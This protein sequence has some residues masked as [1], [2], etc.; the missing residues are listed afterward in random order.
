VSAFANGSGGILFL[1]GEQEKKGGRWTWPGVALAE[2][3]VAWIDQ[4]IRSGVDPVPLFVPHV[5]GHGTRGPVIAIAIDPVPEPPC[6]TANGEVFERVP[7]RSIPVAT[8]DALARLSARGEAARRRAESSAKDLMDELF[9]GGHVPGQ[10]GEV[11]WGVALGSTSIAVDVGA[12]I[13][14]Q[15]FADGVQKELAS[16]A[17]NGYHTSLAG[18]FTP[19]GLAAW[20]HEFNQVE[21]AFMLLSE[22]G[23]AAFGWTDPGLGSGLHLVSDDALTRVVSSL[24]RLLRQAGASGRAHLVLAARPAQDHPLVGALIEPVELQRSTEHDAAGWVTLGSGTDQEV[25]RRLI[26]DLTRRHGRTALEPEIA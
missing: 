7:G 19:F 20:I 16:F 17:Q 1:G 25:I 10:V 21:G 11:L 23:A 18:R 24:G 22:A 14:R 6:L 9:L 15:S 2:E 26:R 8:S 13:Y 12:L 3:P 5:V 4:V